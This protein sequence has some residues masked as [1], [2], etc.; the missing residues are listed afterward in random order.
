MKKYLPNE[1]KNVVLLGSSGS[2]K[3]TMAEAMAFEGSVI[4][5][6]GSV[7]QNNT[8]SDYTEIE[9]IYKRSIYPTQLFAEFNGYKL[10]IIDTPGSDDF[11]GGLFSAF[12]VAD[13]GVMLINAVNG[14]E[15]GTEIQARYAR[16]HEK[17]IIAV[18]NQLDNEKASWDL[19]Y[20]SLKQ[21]SHVKTV[22]VQYP[23]NP[24]VGFDSFI[25]V[26]LMKCYKFDGDTGK[27]TEVP[28]PQ[29]EVERANALHNE[30]VEAAAENDE[31][32]MEM[33]FEKGN[34]TQDEIRGG[35]KLGISK[36]D[37]IPV[38]CASA[39]KDIGTKRLMEFIT[40]VAPGPIKAPN[41]TTID[42][43]EIDPKADGATAIFI[44][45]TAI[46]PHL[47]EVSYFRVITG[48]VKR[49]K[50][51]QIITIQTK[52]RSLN[53]MLQQEKVVLR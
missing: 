40:Y 48:T 50:N 15:A 4:D 32:L 9:H 47:G 1:I 44:Y 24:G 51:S 23:L 43:E 17:P 42:G 12:K 31:S 14:F 2:G 49:H 27:R 45:K 20:E 7:E 52:R 19:A 11:C 37:V 10:N 53:Y 36:R 38:L 22:L 18:I 6:R 34:L 16:K 39:R 3:T 21:N 29:E 25:D 46:E 26:L 13:V 41:F 5:R 33:Y 30:L 35:L 8:L 28:I